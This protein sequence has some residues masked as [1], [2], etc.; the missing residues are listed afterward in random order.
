MTWLLGWRASYPGP[1]LIDRLELGIERIDDPD[2]LEFDALKIGAHDFVLYLAVSLSLSLDSEGE[3]FETEPAR[4]LREDDS[5]FLVGGN[6]ALQF[7]EIFGARVDPTGCYA[8]QNAGDPN[9]MF[10][11]NVVRLGG[12]ERWADLAHFGE[13]E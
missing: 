6:N 2:F 8:V 4:I 13:G 7:L 11:S 10:T 1:S 12:F 5:G 3:P 9:L